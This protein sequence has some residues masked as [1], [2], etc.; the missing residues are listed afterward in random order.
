MVKLFDLMEYIPCELLNGVGHHNCSSLDCTLV[1]L[2]VSSKLAKS[3]PL[4]LPQSRILG[5]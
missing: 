5:M 3:E 1:I 4:C 2:S